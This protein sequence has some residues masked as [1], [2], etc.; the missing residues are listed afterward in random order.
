VLL[1][2][3]FFYKQHVSNCKFLDYRG[4][5]TPPLVLILLLNEMIRNSPTYSREKNIYTELI[6]IVETFISLWLS[7]GQ[8]QN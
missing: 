8:N 1:L 2:V 6:K 7:M 5:V 3:A 4:G